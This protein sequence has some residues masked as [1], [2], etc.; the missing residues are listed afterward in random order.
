[1]KLPT[2]ILCLCS[3]MAYTEV[4]AVE[5]DRA[6][7][8]AE[9]TAEATKLGIPPC[10]DTSYVTTVCYGLVTFSIGDEY[11]GP[12][13]PQKNQFGFGFYEWSDGRRYLGEFLVTDKGT[14]TGLGKMVW[15]DGSYACVTSAHMG[16]INCFN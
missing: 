2:I 7:S 11:F 6:D 15:P 12:I 10:A 16:P 9:V 5:I 4:V 13:H 8:I 3:A 1:M 14:K